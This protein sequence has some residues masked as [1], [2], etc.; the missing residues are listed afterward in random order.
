MR[1][2]YSNKPH[3]AFTGQNRHTAQNAGI[4]AIGD[5]DAH[6][7]QK[8]LP[9]LKPSGSAKEAPRAAAGDTDEV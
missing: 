2:V 5:Y 6:L 3:R 7:D 9:F 4:S 1:Y 8:I